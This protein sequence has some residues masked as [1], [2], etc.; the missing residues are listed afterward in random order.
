M[1]TIASR[2]LAARTYFLRNPRR[3]IPITLV[4]ALV[5]ALE[6]A[7]ITPTNVFE[8]TAEAYIRPLE[9]LTIVTALTRHD[10][11]DDL[12][13]VLDENPHMERRTKAKMLW[14]DTPAIIGELASPLLALT[15]DDREDLMRRLGLHLV[16]GAMPKEGAPGAVLHVDL[17]RAR[18]MSLGDEFGRIVNPDDSTP[19]RFVLVGLLDGGPRLGIVDFA[20][21]SIPD[22]V[23]ARRPA[24]QVV[25]A[26]TGE[27]EESDR[28]LREA[29]DDEG[30]ALFRVV[31]E[32][33]AR[34]L[35][36]KNLRNLPLVIG[37]ITAAAAV[38]V[39]FVVMLISVIGFQS[40]T[41]EFALFLAVGH[42]RA[43]LIRKLATETTWTACCGWIGGVLLGLAIVWGYDRLL[44]R[45][46][47]LVM[48]VVD[49][50]PLL[51]SVLTPVLSALASAAALA[52]R[53]RRMDPVAVIQRRGA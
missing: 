25:Y 47:A 19:G 30:H 17:A 38:I 35:T 36:A 4:I 11:D 51:Y 34:R 8:K 27:K 22:F 50:A 45:P 37:F 39:A 24:F 43:R 2:A 9:S 18:G 46:R 53:L 33:W 49:P 28:Y 10:I 52:A 14:I 5:V 15:P 32:Q 42:R 48:E 13:R 7:V 29:K 12:S 23:L 26:K 41:D 20:Y 3:V 44:L 21:A 6:I 40:R 1:S 31:D 16:A